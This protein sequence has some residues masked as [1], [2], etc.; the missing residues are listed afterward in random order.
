MPSLKDK[1]PGKDSRLVKRGGF[2]DQTTGAMFTT[3]WAWRDSEGAYIGHN[4]EVWLYRALP[5]HPLEWEDPTTRM[6]L[7]KGLTNLLLEVG[8]MSKDVGGVQQLSRLRE[9]HLVQITWEELA[10]PP[11][12]TPEALRHYLDQ[13]L[14]FLIPVKALLVGVQLKSSLASAMNKRAS[15]LRSI[16]EIMQNTVTNA[17]GEGV[18]DMDAYEEDRQKV[19][20]IFDR[21]RAKV[22]TR[23]QLN[24]LESWFNLGRGPDVE[25]YRTRDSLVVDRFDTIEFGAVLRFEDEL[26]QAPWAQW[27]LDA[28]SHPAGPT[29][30]SVRGQLMPNLTARNQLRRSMRRIRANQEEESAVDDI[31]RQ[32]IWQSYEAA[33]D[34]ESWV[35]ASRQPVVSNCSIVFGRR[36]TEAADETYIDLLRDMHGIVVKPLD[37]RQLDALDE[38]LPC[39]DR[40]VGQPFSQVNSISTLSYAGLQGHTVLG[41]PAG[42][43]IGL[44]DPDWV[45]VYLNPTAAPAADLPPAMGIFGD[46]GSGKTFLSQLIAIQTAKA[47]MTTVMINPKGHDTLETT[48]EHVG[49]VTVKLTQLEKEGGWF[50]PFRYAPPHIAAEIASSHILSV[51]QMD[52]EQELSLSYGLRRGSQEGARCVMEAL[53]LGKV[54]PDVIERVRQQ[55]EA[56]STFALGIGFE[57]QTRLDDFRG[58]TLIEFDRKLDLPEETTTDAASYTRPQRIA[59]AALRLVTRASL[60]LLALSGGG[61]LIVDEAHHFLSQPEGRTAVLG[62]GREGRSL[63]ILPIFA[64]QKVSDLLDYGMDG[65]MSRVFAM[66]LR[67][68]EQ[69]TAALKLCGLEPTPSRIEFLRDCGVKRDE[70]NKVISP[71]FALHRDLFDRHAAVAIGPAPEETMLAISTNPEDRKKR[72]AAKQASAEEP[73]PTDRFVEQL[74]T[75]PP[76]VPSTLA[77]DQARVTAR[78]NAPAPVRIVPGQPDKPAPQGTEGWQQAAQEAAKEME[79]GGWL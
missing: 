33:Q 42:V 10:K 14:Q 43:Y 71:A 16:I 68:A 28:A 18:P 63:N 24:Q 1:L 52:E 75:D 34:A 41:D 11:E 17:I 79:D 58:F 38:F 70:N 27:A 2:H 78:D 25:I 32:E 5:L 50:D 26:L 19:T 65:F 56:S 31:G 12:G 53:H 54:R 73:D 76:E 44:G 6:G 35:L 72:A 49:G 46:P 62:M 23:E 74:L 69:A 51:L 57:P 40:R 21:H 8:A 48:A 15:G 7:A 66:K 36:T 59:L 60:E 55:A 67:D 9:F 29:A 13:T 30:I 3:P 37:W 20:A 22:P 64:T 47:G 45:P 39:S 77:A 61:V 4:G